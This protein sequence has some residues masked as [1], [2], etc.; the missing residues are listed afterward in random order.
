MVGI[1]DKIVTF[2]DQNGVVIF[3]ARDNDTEKQI[4]Y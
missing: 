1:Y 3:F 4:L 2:D